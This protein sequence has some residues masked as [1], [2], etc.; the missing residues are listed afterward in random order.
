MIAITR[1]PWLP[2]TIHQPKSVINQ[3]DVPKGF[4]N[5]NSAK[6][7]TFQ[8][9]DEGSKYRVESSKHLNY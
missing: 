9:S 8:L 2:I 1:T 3:S 7:Q 5:E 6:I 4:K